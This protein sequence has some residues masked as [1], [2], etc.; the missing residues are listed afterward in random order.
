[1]RGAIPP[2]LPNNFMTYTGKNVPVTAW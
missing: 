2:L 1:M